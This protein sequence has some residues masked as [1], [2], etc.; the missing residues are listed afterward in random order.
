MTAFLNIY[1]HHANAYHQMIAAEDVDRNLLPTIEQVTPLKGKRI[2]DLGTGTG[3]LPLLYQD[4]AVQVTGLDLHRA[5]LCEAKAQRHQ[6]NGKWGLVQGDMR[7][8]PFPSDWYDVVTAGW[9]IGHFQDWYKTD[10]QQ[11]VESVLVEMFR[12]VKTGGALVIIETL[13]TG[14]TIPTP[15]HEGLANY[16][17]C[18]EEKWGFTCQEIKTDYLFESVEQAVQQTEFF[19]GPELAEKIRAKHWKRLPEWTGVWGRDNC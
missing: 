19:F 11:Q 16:Y 8:L 4:K 17:T 12:V 9:A 3:R 7:S 1:Q 5:M 2:L 13:S 6:S 14:S 10:W 15:P 18:L